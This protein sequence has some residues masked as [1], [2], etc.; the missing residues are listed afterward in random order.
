MEQLKAAKAF[1]I[2]FNSILCRAALMVLPISA[3]YFAGGKVERGEG[4]VSGL[5]AGRILVGWL[6]G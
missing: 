6:A 3:P 4:D 2:S 1:G 5:V